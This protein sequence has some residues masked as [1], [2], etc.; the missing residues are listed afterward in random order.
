MSP[1]VSP[2]RLGYALKLTDRAI[3]SAKT[4]Q[5]DLFLSDGLGLYL[6]VRPSGNKTWLYRYKAEKRT[7]WHELGIYPDMSL[8]DARL[9][10]HNAKALRKS[11]EDPVEK[12]IA[13]KKEKALARVS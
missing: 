3:K 4:A 10:T 7:K 1:E 6:R 8:A 5:K 9:A 13:I 2:T 11:G 12:K